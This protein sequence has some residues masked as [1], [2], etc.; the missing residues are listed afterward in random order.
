M[1]ASS[2]L[3]GDL[4]TPLLWIAFLDRDLPDSTELWCWTV[5]G[6]SVTLTI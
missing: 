6:M 2:Y 5:Y 4:E 3:S 1:T